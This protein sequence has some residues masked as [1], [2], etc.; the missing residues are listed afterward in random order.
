MYLLYLLFQYFIS[1]V[2]YFPLET[3]CCGNFS[4]ILQFQKSDYG[5]ISLI[6]F[7]KTISIFKKTSIGIN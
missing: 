3:I 1:L 2:F 7:L 6:G 4:L 5:N